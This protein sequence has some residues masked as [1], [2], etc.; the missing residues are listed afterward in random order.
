ME[1]TG[2]GGGTKSAGF[3]RALI[4]PSWSEA[5]KKMMM[6]R[7]VGLGR[8]KRRTSRESRMYLP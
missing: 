7:L 5:M 6:D 3:G 1:W 4:V 2:G 8:E